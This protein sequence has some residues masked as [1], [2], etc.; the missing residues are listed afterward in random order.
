VA[1]RTVAQEL[2]LDLARQHYPTTE[3]RGD[4]SGHAAFFDSRKAERVLGW[5]HLE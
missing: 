1:G 5:Q 2:S 3:I 4:L